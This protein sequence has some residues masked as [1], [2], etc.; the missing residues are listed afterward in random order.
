MSLNRRSHAL[1][2]Q[3]WIRALALLLIYL[4]LSAVWGNFVWSAE[5]W[6][7]L[8][9]VLSILLVYLFRKFIDRRTFTS[10]GFNI[11]YFYPDSVI[12][13]ALGSF[14]VFTGS[15]VMYYIDSI[16]WTEVIFNFGDLFVSFILL[17]MIAFSEELV[18]RGYLIRNLMK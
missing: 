17:A 16:R 9:F 15:L 18:F 6:F 4:A 3:G 10:L 8:S 7:T 1:I 2:E 14:L 11:D 5:L 13:F 12:G